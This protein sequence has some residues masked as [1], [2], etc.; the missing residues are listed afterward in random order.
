MSDIKSP[1]STIVRSS[2][3]EL[4]EFY[5]KVSVLVS[6]ARWRELRELEYEAS[7]SALLF[8]N[9]GR[10]KFVVQANDEFISK[11]LYVDGEF[12]LGK[13]IKALGI[14]GRRFETLVD[15]GANIGSICIPAVSRGWVDKAIAIEPEPTNY[16][17]LSA[18]IL[19]N[20]VAKS[21]RALNV[22]AG[23]N[24]GEVLELELSDNNKGDHRIFV[25]DEPGRYGE[26]GRRRLQVE[27]STLDTILHDVDLES[28]L[29]WIDI[30][31]YEGQV[32]A[33]A[34]DICSQAVPAVLEFWPYGMRRARSYA[35]LKSALGSYSQFYDLN[36]DC[37]SPTP[38][39]DEA[40]DSLYIALGEEGAFTDILVM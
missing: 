10:E 14:L 8:S 4:I 12:D 6:E 30:Q 28:A 25:S 36:A 31:G 1:K 3:E 35:A 29:L 9:C 23:A 40:L 2:E 27:V 20:D 5:R 34:R 37:L 22:A 7:D 15:V 19:I 11:G 24:V 26:A 13:A 32:L 39:S 18:N 38:L 33:G 16:R 21:I 17:L